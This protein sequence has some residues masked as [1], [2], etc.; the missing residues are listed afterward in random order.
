MKLCMALQPLPAMPKDV[1][2][3]EGHRGSEMY[4]IVSGE[5][6]VSQLIGS[7]D[8][9]TGEVQERLAVGE[10]VVLLHPPSNFSRCFDMDG[11]RASAK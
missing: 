11:E 7:I 1:I 3:E 4:I 10:T 6:Q 2:I 9:A 8:D 5:V